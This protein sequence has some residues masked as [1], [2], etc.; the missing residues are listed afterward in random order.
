MLLLLSLIILYYFY[1]CSYIK[2]AIEYAKNNDTMKAKSENSWNCLCDE[3]VELRIAI[4][5]RKPA[6][7]FM[8]FFD[9]IHSILKY[10]LITYLPF[11]FRFYWLTWTIIFPFIIPAAIKLA[12]R[13]D[14]YGCIRNHCRPNTNHICVINRK[15]N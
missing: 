2:G 10:V 6:D 12:V 3:L 8:E 5:E 7:I 13:Y 14:N 9:V 4:Y 11:E 15:I 1:G